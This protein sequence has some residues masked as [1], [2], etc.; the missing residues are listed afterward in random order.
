MKLTVQ[1]NKIFAATG[2]R[3]LAPELPLV[4]FLHGSGMD[5]TVWNL[6]TR[7]FAFHGYSVLAIDFPGHGRSEGLPLE[8]IEQMADWIPE[9]ISKAIEASGSGLECA[10]LVGHSMG[11]L[12][13]L[14]CAARYPEKVRA[15]CLM[16]VSAKMAVHPVL[17]EAALKDDPIAYDLVTSWGHGPAG[18]L[19]RTPVPGLSLI[20]GG[21]ALLSSAPKGVLGVGLTAC[22]AYQNGMSAAGK[23]RCSTLC[24][25]GSDDNMTPPRNGMELA[26]AISK[27]KFHLIQDCGHMMMLENSDESLKALKESFRNVETEH[28]VSAS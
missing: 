13:A 9:L 3:V 11:A 22:D 16:G 7:Y 6:Q 17:L 12:V 2:G 4:I 26:S 27:A 5:H 15:L 28:V 14:E 21:R 1:N 8:S 20:G 18:H 23:V 24:I 19:G 10:S 25:I